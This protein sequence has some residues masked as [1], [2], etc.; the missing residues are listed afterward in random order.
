MTLYA[1]RV[2]DRLT[3]DDPQHGTV[4]CADD[5]IGPWVDMVTGHIEW[6]WEVCST[7]T[8]VEENAT[9]SPTHGDPLSLD[10]VNR[11]TVLFWEMKHEGRVSAKNVIADAIAEIERLQS[12]V[13]SQALKLLIAYSEALGLYDEV[14]NG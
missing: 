2:H 9:T 3:E 13:R 8:A 6:C 4:M 5:A 1:V 7:L 14:D 11:L 10:I 12:K